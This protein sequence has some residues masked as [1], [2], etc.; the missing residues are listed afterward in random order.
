MKSFYISLFNS[1]NKSAKESRLIFEGNKPSSSASSNTQSK[2]EKARAAAKAAAE[3]AKKPSDVTPASLKNKFSGIATKWR[4]KAK[5]PGMHTEDFEQKMEGLL[6]PID[7]Q[8]TLILKDGLT[9]GEVAKFNKALNCVIKRAKLAVKINYARNKVQEMKKLITKQ[10]VNDKIEGF[11]MGLPGIVNLSDN[12]IDIVV[13]RLQNTYGEKIHASIH[14]GLNAIDTELKSA[15]TENVDKIIGET[16]VLSKNSEEALEDLGDYKQIKDVKKVIQEYVKS[17]QI[18]LSTWGDSFGKAGMGM[19]G[20]AKVQFDKWMK[21]LKGWL[22]DGSKSIEDF[23]AET[24]KAQTHIIAA[25][26]YENLGDDEQDALLQALVKASIA[27][28]GTNKMTV[29]L[30]IKALTQTSIGYE[31]LGANNKKAAGLQAVTKLLRSIVGKDGRIKINVEGGADSDKIALNGKTIPTIIG[32]QKLAI[33]FGKLKPENRDKIINSN[34]QLAASADFLVKFIALSSTAPKEGGKSPLV[35]FLEKNPDALGAGGPIN[36]LLALQRIVSVTGPLNDKSIIFQDNCTALAT[37]ATGKSKK[38]DRRSSIGLELN[39]KLDKLVTLPKTEMADTEEGRIKYKKES[40]L[41]VINKFGA[42]NLT[43]PFKVAGINLTPDSKTNEEKAFKEGGEFIFSGKTPDNKK[44]TCRLSMDT[45]ALSIGVEGEDSNGPLN[46]AEFK[47]EMQRIA[48][49]KKVA[50]K[51]PNATTKKL[52]AT[53]KTDADAV[54]K[55]VRD[56]LRTQPNFTAR[57]ITENF[58]AGLK[59]ANTNWAPLGISFLPKGMEQAGSGN[60]VRMKG[61]S[62][63]YIYGKLSNHPTLDKKELIIFKGYKLA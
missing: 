5:R 20:A 24:K 42:K 41:L 19:K 59:E 29:S 58:P 40:V 15:S 12:L 57:T 6:G 38:S 50:T 9:K 39:V 23:V 33:S 7:A 53:Q 10:L 61:K 36:T 44:I 55:K 21:D 47:K 8:L 25:D 27:P 63:E 2:A 60:F 30:F 34:P 11:A 45:G 26:I 54:L 56:G 13:T 17:I 4:D 52:A 37:A 49:T 14:K 51:K 48:A 35:T 62:G 16:S 28:K 3:E 22:T 46:T 18:V 1:T 43:E 31:S 32:L